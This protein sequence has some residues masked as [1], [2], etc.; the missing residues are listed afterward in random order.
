M[1][2]DAEGGWQPT[3]TLTSELWGKQQ[4][5]E[6]RVQVAGASLVFDA[7]QIASPTRRGRLARAL[8]ASDPGGRRGETFVLLMLE[9]IPE[10]AEWNACSISY[11]F[12]WNAVSI[13]CQFL[14]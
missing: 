14:W 12:S 2:L 13:P 7:A 5:L 6:Q 8:R 3:V 1:Q 9:K 10:H 4:S 11:R